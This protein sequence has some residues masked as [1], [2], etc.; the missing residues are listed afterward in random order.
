MN[1]TNYFGEYLATLT[2]KRPIA[3]KGMIRLAVKDKY[4]DRAPEQL[5]YSELRVIFDTTL[6]QRLENVD[7]PNV[8]QITQSIIEYLIQNQSILTMA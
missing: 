5:N 8:A 7:I 6:K 4:P 2:G 3:C 1:I